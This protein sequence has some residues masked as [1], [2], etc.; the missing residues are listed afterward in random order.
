LW[1]IPAVWLALGGCGDTAFDPF[2]ES[3]LTYSISGYLDASIDTQFVRVTPVRGSIALGPDPFDA[4]VM[5]E[6]LT[7]GRTTFLRD[8]LFRYTTPQDERSERYAHNYWT[9]EPILPLATYR[10]TVTR[11]DGARSAATVT[12]PDTFPDP[13][14]VG[15]LIRM[16]GIERF[17][18]VKAVYWVIDL[19]ARQVVRHS[20]SYLGAITLQEDEHRVIID[21]ARDQANITV[22]LGGAPMRVLRVRVTVAAAGPGWPD[23]AEI[24]EE[25]LALSG[26]ISNV[27]DGVGFLG[28]IVSKTLTLF[29]AGIPFDPEALPV[30]P[31]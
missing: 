30:L 5:L 21:R 6:H 25:T 29:D 17:A 26:V 1:A 13:V 22:A 20:V 12:L 19:L 4:L 31:R 28:G 3:N 2:E 8:S 10:L 7:T 16:Q 24:D 14:V 27:E 18:D 15:N 9:T 11:S 23:L